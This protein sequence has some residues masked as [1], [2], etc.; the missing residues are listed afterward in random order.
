MTMATMTKAKN[1]SP[2][3]SG[4][5]KGGRKPGV[6]SGVTKE[7]LVRFRSERKVS[8]ALLAKTLGVSATSI[9]NWERGSAIPVKRTQE[10]LR[11]VIDGPALSQR[12]NGTAADVTPEATSRSDVRDPTG[13]AM[14]VATI[15]AATAPKGETGEALAVRIRMVRD[16]LTG[17]S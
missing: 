17:R 7:E 4:G 2:K 14:A 13:L 11:A 12:E 16:A 8:R 1:K 5:R 3:L 9:Q 6:W 15:V 10:A